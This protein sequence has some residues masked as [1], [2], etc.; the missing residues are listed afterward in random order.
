MHSLSRALLVAAL[1]APLAGAQSLSHVRVSVPDAPALA[2]TLEQEGFDV[3]E[4]SVRAST[5]DLVVSEASARL[6]TSRGLELELI[7][8]GRPF[9]EI[10]AEAQAA[11]GTK[12]V[13][14]G[15]SDLTDILARMN[16]AAAANPTLA[17]VVDLTAKYGLSATHEGRH[18]HAIKISD[19]VGTDEDEPNALIV[20]NHHAR[21]I[22]TPEIALTAM[23]KLLAGYGGDPTI[24]SL[25]NGFEI[26]IVPTANPDGYEYVFNVNNLWRK[27]RRNNGGGIFG[28]DTNRNYPFLW[29]TPCSGSTSP[30]TETYKGP[31]A[32]SEPETQLITTFSE[33]RRFAYVV[34]YHSYGSEVLWA[35]ATCSVHPF[36]VPFL[37]PEAIAFSNASGY[38]GQNR[39]PSADGE[40]Y[41][42]QLGNYMN[43]AFLI[44]THTTFQPSYASAVAEANKLWPG[45][46]YMLQRPMPLSGHVTDALSGLP[47]QASIKVQGINFTKGE[48]N[49]SGGP[50]GR[51]TAYVP[52]GNYNLEV[53]ADCYQTQVLPVSVNAASATVL[54]VALQPGSTP[55]VYCTAKT[56]SQGCTPSISGVG[57]P[58]ASSGSGFVVTGSLLVPK[59]YGL[60]VYSKTGPAAN[61]F[62]GGFLC[63]ASPLRRT[64]GQ[65]SGGAAPCSGQ[66]SL[67]FNDWIQTGGDAGLVAGV[68]VW[69]QYWSRDPSASFGTNLTDAISFTLCP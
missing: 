46:L 31:S 45:I 34:D 63:I 15:Y 38:G 68:T 6:L 42:W 17:Q 56:N 52:T 13:P 57:L 69:G 37:L 7:A 12:A 26:W 35:Y 41:Q 25:V 64:N 27:N 23:D 47:V 32:G 8:V 22:V 1:L 51:Y 29:S 49:S 14:A 11:A 62:Q 3:V 28:V 55:T 53:S 16:A 33:D 44:E 24:T 10:Q 30:S 9:R 21:E 58:S 60:F 61:P 19:N 59:V 39:Q 50:F 66:L 65:T 5:L 18:I 20:S 36:G 4:G 43:Y 67:D 48:T 2:E 40:H 54:D